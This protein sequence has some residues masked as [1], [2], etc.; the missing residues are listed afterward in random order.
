MGK[1]VLQ[2]RRQFLVFTQC[3]LHKFLLAERDLNTAQVEVGGGGGARC[4]AGKSVWE[5]NLSGK[6]LGNP[7]GKGVPEPDWQ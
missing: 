1:R 2:W 4:R 7:V 3:W 5:G 6:A